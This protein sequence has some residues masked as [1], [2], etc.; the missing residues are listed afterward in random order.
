MSRSGP[1]LIIGVFALMIAGVT[2]YAACITDDSETSSM[3]FSF[4]LGA[5]WIA[6]TSLRREPPQD[7]QRRRADPSSD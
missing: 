1:Y 2:A 6:F 5:A 3:S 4:A 7:A